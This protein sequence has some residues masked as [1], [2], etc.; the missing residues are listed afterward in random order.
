MEVSTK[1]IK[2]LEDET[3]AITDE[4]VNNR[5]DEFCIQFELAQSL[6]AILDLYD[7]AIEALNSL[8]TDNNAADIS[9]SYK[10]M[11]AE[12]LRSAIRIATAKNRSVTVADA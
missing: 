10:I 12:A 5:I 4:S 7:K 8:K 11:L 1:E 2:G 3:V 6:T 9:V